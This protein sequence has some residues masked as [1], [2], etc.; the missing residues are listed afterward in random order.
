MIATRANREGMERA[1]RALA[2]ILA[3]VLKPAFYGRASVRFTVV[4]GTI[5]QVRRKVVRIERP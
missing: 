4:D 3:A 1:R 2:E 5:I